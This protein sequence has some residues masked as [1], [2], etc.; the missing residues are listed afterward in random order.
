MAIFLAVNI[1]CALRESQIKKECIITMHSPSGQMEANYFFDSASNAGSAKSLASP[2]RQP[3]MNI[4]AMI[5]PKM[6][7]DGFVPSGSG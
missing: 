4:T 6:K 5:I 1:F 2:P 7:S 3:L